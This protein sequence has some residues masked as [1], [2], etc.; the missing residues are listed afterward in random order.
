M[1]SHPPVIGWETA[2]F[3]VLVPAE[4]E[5]A[6]L[7]RD[8]GL[9]PS[10]YISLSSQIA[11]SLWAHMLGLRFL[12]LSLSRECPHSQVSGEACGGDCRGKEAMEGLLKQTGR[13]SSTA[14]IKVAQGGALCVSGVNLANPQMHLFFPSLFPLSPPSSHLVMFIVCQLYIPLKNSSQRPTS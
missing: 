13:A 8:S 3:L 7:G 11:H 14:E 4:P 9:G 6:C 1:G 10:E 12:V 2:C 5:G